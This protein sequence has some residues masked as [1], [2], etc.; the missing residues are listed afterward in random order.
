M[1]RLD[2]AAFEVPA[3]EPESDGTHRWESTTMVAVRASA[4]GRTGLGY[5]YTAA[6]A[7]RLIADELAGLALGSD[8]MAPPATWRAMVGALR[9]VGRP[10]ISSTAAAAVDCALWDLKARL[11]DLPLVRL[12]GGTGRPVPVYGSGG[13]TSLSRD[14]LREQLAGWVD[15]GIPRVKMKVGRRPEEDVDRVRAA[16]EAVGP[17][18]DLMVDA[19]GAYDRKEALQKGRA[20]A[21]PG[22]TWFEEP[23][24]SDDLEGLR[25]LRDRM[26][27]PIEVTAGEYG[28]DLFYFR[29]MMDAG[30]VDVLQADVTRCAGFTEFMRVGALCRARPLPLSAHTAPA[31]HLHPCSAL[32]TTRHVEWFRD[33]VRVGRTLLDGYPSPG[34]G[35]IAP[36]LSRP[37]H[38]LR[39]RRADADEY[40]VFR[41]E[42]T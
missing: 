13:F 7:A 16:R 41:E 11:L 25:L 29:R 14:R 36:D 20:F 23:V 21:D 26:P 18:A 33:H 34:E 35:S 10:G 40:E 17:G 9:N 3:G 38:G 32:A 6:A 2:V 8:A 12:L 15:A 5:S 37:G 39:L 30:A 4:D 42:A 31:L 19:N 24:S 28:F 27:A 22:V 1:D